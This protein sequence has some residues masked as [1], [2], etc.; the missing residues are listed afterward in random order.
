MNTER[1]IFPDIVA[2]TT[3]F[4]LQGGMYRIGAVINGPN[5]LQLQ[6]L[7]LD[8]QCWVDCLDHPIAASG[9]SEEISIVPGQYRFHPLTDLPLS[10]AITCTSR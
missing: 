1:V 10:A 6:T 4:E 3:P 2:D 5:N 9:L 7:A 8:G